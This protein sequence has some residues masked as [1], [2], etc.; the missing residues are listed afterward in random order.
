MREEWKKLSATELN[1][2]KRW[3]RLV[4]LLRD[5]G[6][7][8]VDTILAFIAFWNILLVVI[9]LLLASQQKCGGRFERFDVGQVAP[10]DITSPF[11]FEHQDETRTMEEREEARSTSIPVYSYD[12]QQEER[13]IS[14]LSFIME[15]LRSMPAEHPS[16]RKGVRGTESRT[17]LPEK[18]FSRLPKDVTDEQLMAFRKISLDERISENLIA[19]LSKIFREKIVV[20]KN[21]LP[22]AIAFWNSQGSSAR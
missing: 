12:S 16:L 1:L 4:F 9:L 7:K 5:K 6:R 20:N 13:L 11:D 17:I 18:V 8:S 3:S 15:E 21:A 10:Y 2:L 14:S 22:A 19:S